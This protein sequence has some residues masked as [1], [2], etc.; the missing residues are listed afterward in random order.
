MMTS[1][2]TK[3]ITA[4]KRKQQVDK[5]QKNSEG[6]FQ[7]GV[8]DPGAAEDVSGDQINLNNY[9]GDVQWQGDH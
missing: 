1:V 9:L 8:P 4:K 3:N 7:V 5:L 2:I 6:V